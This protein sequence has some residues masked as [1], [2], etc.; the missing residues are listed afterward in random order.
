[1]NKMRITTSSKIN[2]KKIKSNFAFSLIELS[3]VILI[4]SILA[5]SGLTIFKSTNLSSKTKVTK[6]KIDAV[7]KAL[8][9][10]L[11]TY[12]RLPCPASLELDNSNASYGNEVRTVP[13]TGPCPSSTSGGVIIS[14]SN[15][16]LVY[17]MIPTKTLG[18]SGDMAEDGF[19]TKLSYIIDKRFAIAVDSSAIVGFEGTNGNDLADGS[20]TLHSNVIIQ[21]KDLSA[22]VILSNAIMVIVSHGTNKFGGFN[23]AGVVQNDPTSATLDEKD[24]AINNFTPSPSLS[25]NFDNTFITS[26]SNT[27][28]DDILIFKNK[29]QLAID[30]GFES[31]L[32]RHAEADY[33]NFE[34]SCSTSGTLHWNDANYGEKNNSTT[35]CPGACI[36]YNPNPPA[37]NLNKSARVC[38]KYGIWGPVLYPCY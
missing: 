7:Y 34:L 9:N 1:M 20:S 29:V 30:A 18:L 13:I 33:S 5:S 38:E 31:M 19:G 16:N 4:I 14:S 3:I 25:G 26:S 15:T 10:Y 23:S 2:N 11:I 28:F 6:D 12:R 24:N 17:G 27:A 21:I 22:S 37:T 35:S 8:G 32:C 36:T